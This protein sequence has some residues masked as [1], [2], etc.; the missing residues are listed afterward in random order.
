MYRGRL[1]RD[2]DLWVGGGLLNRTTADTLLA[3]YDSRRSAF[4]V[5]NVLMMLAAVLLA[6]AV[7]MLVAANWDAIPRLTRVIGIFA[8]IW[9]FNGA[10][11]TAFARNADR[12]GGALLLLAT[13]SFGGG[14]AL[15]AQLYN[16]SGDAVDAILLWFAVTAMAAVAYRSG[17]LTIVCG[18]LSWWVFATYL[19]DS[20][21]HWDT[22]YGFL[23]PLM[24]LV[25]ILL[26]RWTETPKAQ[27]LAYL[28]LLGWF[29]WL[30]S[31]FEGQGVA[32]LYVAVG[33]VLFVAA[34][35]K[36]SPLAPLARRRGA[37]PAFYAFALA[38]LGVA[39]LHTL[40]DHGA[41][42][43]EIAVVTIG[44][45]IAGLVLDGRDNGA[46]R[47]LAYAAFAGEILYLAFVTIDSILGTSGFFL[48]SGLVLAVLAAVVLW[49]EKMFA[50]RNAGQVQP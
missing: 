36:G 17:V 29:A 26:M 38:L 15:V 33:S 25:T 22:F 12:V 45:A 48:L 47:Y 37:A 6:A 5:G 21:G 50:R 2:F 35:L 42:L 43:A 34:T 4:S 1:G 27:H 31:L 24:A 41:G 44:L 8:L 16:L 13:A 3:E 9:G 40:Y 23:P 7:L 19:T 20:N 49:M 11:A 32:W 28:Q 30:Y 18:F 39:I 10:A 46:V 14:I